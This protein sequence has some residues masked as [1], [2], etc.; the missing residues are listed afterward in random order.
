ME[1]VADEVRPAKM[2]PTG[3]QA[4][5]GSEQVCTDRHQVD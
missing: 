2:L 1:Q 5:R 3:D 4:L